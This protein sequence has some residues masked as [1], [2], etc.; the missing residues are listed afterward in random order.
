MRLQREI[1]RDAV[2]SKLADGYSV[3]FIEAGSNHVLKIDDSGRAI[4]SLCDDD[5]RNWHEVSSVNLLNLLRCQF[6]YANMK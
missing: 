4:V 5:T 3:Y 6:F 2:I 1:N